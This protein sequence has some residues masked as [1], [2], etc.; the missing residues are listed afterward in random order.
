MTAQN[1]EQMINGII[2]N[3]QKLRSDNV[4]V[5]K[6]S[7]RES[8]LVITLTEGK[9]REVRRLCSSVG[10]EVTKLKRVAY[11]GLTLDNMSPGEYKELNMKEIDAAFPGVTCIK[12]LRF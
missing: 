9:N 8:H 4:V 3:N 2:D 12:G 11:G 5:R 1:A 7:R 10:H 6:S